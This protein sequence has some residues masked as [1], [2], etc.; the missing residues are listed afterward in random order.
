M[1]IILATDFS[2]D[3][4]HAAE[5][6][7]LLWGTE[8][9]YTL[10]T[11]YFD[12]SLAEPAGPS[13]T[14]ALYEAAEEGS[15]AF[16]NELMARTNTKDIQREVVF[17]SEPD[18]AAYNLLAAGERGMLVM[19]N[20]GKSGIALF[21]SNTLRAIK[22]SLIPVLAVPQ[23]TEL[24][25][26]RRM[27]FADDLRPITP[28]DLEPLRLLAARTNAE[29]IIGHVDDPSAPAPDPRRDLSPADALKDIRH[30]KH[31]I[32]GDVVTGIATLADEDQVDLLCS[33]HRYRN[34][35]DRFFH[36]S[37]TKDVAERVHR[38]LLVLE[39]KR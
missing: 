20:R 16:A 10:L 13:M 18:A 5:Y 6:A 7:I 34:F 37:I 3:A 36:H 32:D 33:L 4:M 27:L 28:M 1:H 23:A 25:Q 17:S 31:R 2:A 29:V 14:Q 39:E 21:G 11:T 19:G 12:N 35:V 15:V 22:H 24:R 38:P 8:A 9:R 30:R 26:P